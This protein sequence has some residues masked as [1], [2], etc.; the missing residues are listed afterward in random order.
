MGHLV[1]LHRHCYLQDL[2]AQ[3]RGGLSHEESPELARIAQRA[4]VDEDAGQVPGYAMKRP[5]AMTSRSPVTYEDSSD[6]RNRQPLATSW[7]MP[8]RPIGI[9]DDSASRP[10][11][12]ISP[13]TIMFTRILC[14]A[15][16]TARL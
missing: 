16:S 15:S 8:R 11:V 4:K 1:D 6:A 14:G 5:P 2:S 12:A 7:G 13:G 10:S 3:S 9:S